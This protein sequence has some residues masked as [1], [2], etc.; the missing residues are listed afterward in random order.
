MP[1]RAVVGGSPFN[2]AIGLARLG[3]RPAFLGGISH[4][5]FGVLLADTLQR[6][7]VDGR[8]LVRPNAL[9]TISAIA[10]GPDGQ[11]SYSFHGEG[12]ADRSIGPTDLPVA[13]PD[14]I[15]ALTFGSYTMV[16]E[17][18]GS[19]FAALAAREA[20]R[21]VISVDPNLRPA[22]V[23]DMDRW[24]LAGERFYRAA[25]IVKASD[26]DI[27]IAWAGRLSIADAA[28]Y[29][30]DCGAR[31]V[32]VT[33]GEQGATA[34]SAAGTVAVPGRCVRVRDTVGAGDTFHAALLAQLSTTGRLDP[35]AIG[36]LDR[37]A[38]GDLLAYAT[39]AAA[40]TCTRRGAD[41]PTAAEVAANLEPHLV[42]A[43]E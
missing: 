12:A 40:I 5:R 2:V 4:D 19:A 42:G 28:A 3:A 13:L 8:F 36:A 14:E 43:L 22:V 1:A 20:G 15:R 41:L 38:I 29:W 21:R 35:Q 39:A 9:S 25:T 27:R 23:G 24:A 6:E 37:E 16:V 32:V 31:L 17:P 30:L 33:A 7:G 26:E 34:F 10:T 11:P 18:V